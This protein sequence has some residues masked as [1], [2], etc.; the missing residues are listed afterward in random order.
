MGRVKD[1]AGALPLAA[2]MA[3]AMIGFAEVEPPVMTNKPET[4]AEYEICLLVMVLVLSAGSGIVTSVSCACTLIPS[5]VST[6]SRSVVLVFT[7]NMVVS[8]L[9]ARAIR[10]RSASVFFPSFRP[11]T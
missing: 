6:F 2:S 3:G 4:S 8:V 9:M 1:S 7:P 10:R 11:N 5:L